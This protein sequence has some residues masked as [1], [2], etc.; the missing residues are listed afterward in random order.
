MKKLLLISL[1]SYT[2]VLSG[3]ANDD[4]KYPQG[5]D[6]IE[7]YGDGR[8]QIMS[9]PTTN[10]FNNLEEQ[11]TIEHIVFKYK[12]IEQYVYVIGES[13]YTVLN[14]QTGEMKKYQKMNE[15]PSEEKEIFIELSK[16]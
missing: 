10:S 15:I 7:I 6:T 14:F 11:D 2:L 13:G 4:Y 16:E 1:L 3:C 12:E 5:R 8:F 9:G